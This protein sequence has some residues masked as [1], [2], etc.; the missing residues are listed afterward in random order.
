MGLFDKLFGKKSGDRYADVPPP[1]KADGAANGQIF[2]DFNFKLVVLEA[3]LGKNLP[4]EAK[5]KE[6]HEELLK[7]GAIDPGLYSP[8]D[9]VRE[10]LANLTLTREELDM[11]TE[12][13]FDGG[14]E[15]YAYLMHNWDGEDD[16]L[17]VTSIGGF[18]YLRN[19]KKAVLISMADESILNPMKQNGILVE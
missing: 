16:I 10:Y 1:S 13:C 17:D 2:E 18:E 7:T 3:L 4:F 14:N 19:L 8:I 11:V 15:I 6:L 9:E 12:L 5:L